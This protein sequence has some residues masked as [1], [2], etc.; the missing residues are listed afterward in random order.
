[1]LVLVEGYD[2][3]ELLKS[4]ILS[5]NDAKII[6]FDF[7]AH[8]S[9]NKSEIPHYLVEEYFSKN[10]ESKIDNLALE[11]ATQWH[12]QDEVAKSLEYDG[13]NL[14]SLLELEMP[15]FFGMQLKR[16]LG[17]IRIIEKEKPLKIISGSLGDFVN[18]VGNNKKIDIV[19]HGSKA[20]SHLHYDSIEIPITIGSKTITL[21]ISR[22]QFLRIKK[23]V[24]ILIDLFI[25]VKP[26]RSILDQKSILLLD[27][28]TLLYQ[29]LLK[30]LSDSPQNIILLNQRRPAIWNLESLRIIKNSKCKII[31]LEDFVITDIIP[32]LEIEQKKIRY[33]L[34]SLWTK[35]HIL[36]NLFSIEGQSFWNAINVN[37]I[38]II[39]KRFEESVKRLLLLKKLFD[40]INVSCI[41]EW[42]HVSME[43]KIM[44]H[45]AN[46]KAIPI[47]F[48]Q[49]GLYIQNTKF[50]K[51]IPIFPILPS[52]GAK[53]AIWGETFKSYL[54]KYNV[55]EKEILASGSPRH[56][57]FFKRRS[58]VRNDGSVL[59]AANSFF[60]VNFSG[61]DTR[62][63]E[64]LESCVKQIFKLLQRIPSKK[65]IVKLHPGYSYYDIK[66]LIHE[67]DPSV[68]IYQDQNIIDLIESCDAMIS[69]NYS[70]VLLDA[71]ILNKPIMLILPDKQNFEEELP[72]KRKA[73]LYVNDI[74]N[75]ESALNDI[76]FNAKVREEL[77]Q[78]GKEFVNDYFSNQGTASDYLAEALRRFN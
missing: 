12:K 67:I 59:I 2:D 41:L 56:D 45:I 13:L 14:G 32:K 52:N 8:K 5:S 31:R 54:Q 72:V 3:V 16:I 23:V 74:T 60:Y 10:D 42:A 28:N 76:L 73:V 66:P 43:E 34:D 21:K 49:H 44:L 6:S 25:N 33:K 4:I 24:E 78:N 57:V 70:T 65:P 48:L 35:E 22:R 39:T 29:D 68:P 20:A 51:Y 19:T 27:F 7:H 30:A 17:I 18:S 1:M 77:I 71:M 46:K 38:E 69:L 75:L 26:D 53:E 55:N 50:E 62:A 47:I 58:N 61:K 15:D 11:L 40:T 9:L 37:F 64:Y 36:N 63:Y